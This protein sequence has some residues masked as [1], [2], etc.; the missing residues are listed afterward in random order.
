MPV[1][2]N[3]ALARL[4]IDPWDEA[5][6]L[7]QMPIL[8][9]TQRLTALIEALPSSYADPATIAAR[10]IGLLPG[11]ASAQSKTGTVRA[12]VKAPD[13]S[14]YSVYIVV[15]LVFGFSVLLSLWLAPDEQSPQSISDVASPSPPPSSH[16][17]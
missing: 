6:A 9:A 2:V 8:A 3:S 1:S 17:D 4:N 12:S 15:M 5:T 10:L 7:S 14:S 13:E 16:A 11:A